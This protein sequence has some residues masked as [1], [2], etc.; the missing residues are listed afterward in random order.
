MSVT[1]DYTAT[2]LAFRAV[3]EAHGLHP[4]AVRVVLALDEME[5]DP[6]FTPKGD[7]ELPP[8]RLT[9]DG[10]RALADA[11]DAYGWPTTEGDD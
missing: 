11:V 5:P 3:G 4:T 7:R 2:H 1:S 9:A 6:S 8:L 10:V